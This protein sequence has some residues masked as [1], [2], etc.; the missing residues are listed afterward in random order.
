MEIKKMICA[1]A[2]LLSFMACS[3]DDVMTDPQGGNAS[4]EGAYMSL[5]I[6]MPNGTPGTRAIDPGSNGTEAGT[7][8]E[9]K[10][11]SLL[12]LC[13]DA[14]SG[15][16]ISGYKKDYLAADL[17]PMNPNPSDNTKAT[18][19][20]VPEFKI[21]KGP[22]KVVVIVNPLESQFSET[23]SLTFMRTAM[24]LSTDQITSISTNN[25]FLMTN[26]NDFVNQDA[27][28]NKNTNNPTENG[29]FYEDGSVYV[30]V[31][32]TKEHPTNVT[33][34]VERAVAKIQDVTNNNNYEFN[35]EV[36]GTPNGEKVTF[37]DVALINGNTKFY[38]IKN[39]RNSNTEGKNDY[40]VDPNFSETEQ[41]VADFYSKIFKVTETETKTDVEFKSLTSTP[42]FYTLENTMH[43]EQQMNGYTTGLYYKAVYTAKDGIKG[44]NVYKYLGK[45]YN[46]AQL[47]QLSDLKLEVPAEGENQ[48]IELTD[49]SSAEDFAKIGVTKYEKGVCYYPYWIRHVPS[50]SVV[51][52]VMEFGVVRNNV[53][54]MTINSV[55]G[56]GT[57]DP[58][59]PDPGTPDETDDVILQVSVKVLPWTIRKN[60][61]DF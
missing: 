46:F 47:G 54:K 40:V 21:A 35:V 37:T 10:V 25:S 27:E 50:S 4:G 42:I 57:P 6:S 56:I 7:D 2:I 33:I 12:V 44:D 20:V 26:A 32:G 5:A 31:Q 19:Y 49:D 36:D 13:Y 17:V 39:I 43:K 29:Q 3:Q 18:I 53:Y 38:P 16:A 58:E 51:M 60:Q 61:I 34:P 23:T 1:G 14:T 24:S 8:E 59:N 45:V 41:K 48:K 28:G 22:K 9:Q 52:D 55:K 15:E 30:D 11:T